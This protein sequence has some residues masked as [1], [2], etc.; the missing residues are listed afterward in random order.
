MRIV[1][2]PKNPA[3]G[4][5]CLNTGRLIDSPIDAVR[6]KGALLHCPCRVVLLGEGFLEGREFIAKLPLHLF[7][8]AQCPIR[9]GN[10]TGTAPAALLLIYQDDSILPLMNSPGGAGFHTGGV[11]AVVAK[12]G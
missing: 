2:V 9:A 12:G 10:N 3:I 11:L 6:T 8:K 5:A 4:W 1:Q 7:H